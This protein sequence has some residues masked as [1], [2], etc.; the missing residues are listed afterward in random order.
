MCALKTLKKR[1]YLYC[2]NEQLL[3][4]ELSYLSDIF[5][6]NGYPATVVH[7]ILFEEKEKDMAIKE[8]I[9]FSRVFYAPY[10][11]RAR[12]L[13]RVLEKQFNITPIFQKTQTLGDLLLKKCRGVDKQY[14]KNAIYKIPCK[15]C[16][17][18]YIGQSKNS[19]KTR[20]GS[21]SRCANQRGRKI[22]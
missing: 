2:S 18:S 21:T 11:P 6:Q 13:Y 19:I 10:H 14:I 9:D 17:I 22:F 4:D 15:S 1:A 5:A 7:R 3:M 12:K 20:T 8:K 16:N